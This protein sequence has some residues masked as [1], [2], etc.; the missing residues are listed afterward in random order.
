MRITAEELLNQRLQCD[1]QILATLD[2]HVTRLEAARNE[3]LLALTAAQESLSLIE[4]ELDDV[5]TR[6]ASLVQNVM[7]TRHRLRPRPMD[8]FPLEL[9]RLIFLELSAPPKNLW[10]NEGHGTVDLERAR[11]PFH[12]A[13]VCRRWRDLALAIPT[14]WSY[15]GVPS[16][17]LQPERRSYYYLYWVTTLLDRSKPAPL[18]ICLPWAG[19]PPWENESYSDRLM[20]TLAEHSL[21]WRHFEFALPRRWLDADMMSQ[22]RRPTPLLETFYL[23]GRSSETEGLEWDAETSIPRYLPACSRLAHFRS[24]YTN[25]LY[26]VPRPP[27][28]CIRTIQVTIKKFPCRVLWDILRGAPA[29]ELLRM[30]FVGDNADDL[31]EA[32]DGPVHLPCLRELHISRATCA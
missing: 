20:D 12:L 21:R 15:I 5:K 14:L 28:A 1:E 25:V 31:E 17:G 9:L 13:G 32:P 24:D 30:A 4:V 19:D 7:E 11:R 23:T 8:A 22:F 29:L 2:T 16:P 6:R 10:P 18:D 27:L 3:A 26:A